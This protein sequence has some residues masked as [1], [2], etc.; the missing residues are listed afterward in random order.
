MR[1]DHFFTIGIFLI[2]IKTRFDDD[3]FLIIDNSIQFLGRN[4]EQITDLVW[5]R[6][7]IPDMSYRHYQVDM[8][9]AL[10]TY[11]LLCYLNATTVAY[12]TLITDTL[13]FSAG[14][15]I[16]LGRTEDTLTEQSVAL[17]FVCTVVD[18]FRFCNLTITTFEDFLRRS[19]SD[20][21]LRKI[22]LY[23]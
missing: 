12:N 1:T 22:I 11:F 9:G 20:S 19:K 18:R 17:G 16:V 15:L 13:V 21:N 4:T 10:T 5:E 3:I 7:E 2:L 14:T 23:L 6:T 8:S